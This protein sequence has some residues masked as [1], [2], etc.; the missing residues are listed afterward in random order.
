[1]STGFDDG[2]TRREGF[3]PSSQPP[4]R[5]QNYIQGDNFNNTFLSFTHT[6]SKRSGVNCFLRSLNEPFGGCGSTAVTSH[7]VH[8]F[9][10]PSACKVD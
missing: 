5:I 10:S 8:F 7:E 3:F 4:T 2:G 9:S 6:L 1:M